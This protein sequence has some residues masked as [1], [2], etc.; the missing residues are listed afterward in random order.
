MPSKHGDSE[1][2]GV[3]G[4]RKPERVS[5]TS[6]LNPEYIVEG[7]LDMVDS[8]HE[9]LVRASSHWIPMTERFL[10]LMALRNYAAPLDR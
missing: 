1:D 3:Y 4:V 10:Y 2:P 8:S 6:Q 9:K 5:K 7:Q